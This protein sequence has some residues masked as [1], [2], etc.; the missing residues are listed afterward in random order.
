MLDQP[1]GV[2]QDPRAGGQPVDGVD[3]PVAGRNT[4]Q[5]TT[6][7]GQIVSRSSPAEDQRRQVAGIG[8]PQAVT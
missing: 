6:V 1:V 7:A 5:H 3:V 4:D 2:Q 8:P